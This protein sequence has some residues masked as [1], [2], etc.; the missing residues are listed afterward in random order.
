MTGL[1]FSGRRDSNSRRQPWEGC[2]LPLN[3]IRI[4]IN[5]AVLR[6]LLAL[7]PQVN[8]LSSHKTIHWIVL[9]GRVL[10]NTSLKRLA[11]VSGSGFAT[12]SRH[13]PYR[14]SFSDIIIILQKFFCTISKH[15]A[16]L[17]IP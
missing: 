17:T 5:K 2:I 1:F 9:L 4:S 13:V 3:Y 11:C 7:L 12:H 6:R 16:A 15:F 14:E 10:S 8:P